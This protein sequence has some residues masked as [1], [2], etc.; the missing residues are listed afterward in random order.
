[1]W[2]FGVSAA[3][4][5]LEPEAVEPSTPPARPQ[6]VVPAAASAHGGAR[7]WL[8]T[9]TTHRERATGPTG[10]ELV[11]DESTLPAQPQLVVSA[12]ASAHGVARAWLPTLTNHPERAPG[13]AGEQVVTD[14]WEPMGGTPDEFWEE[15]GEGQLESFFNNFTDN[16][17][18]RAVLSA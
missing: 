12:M 17:C 13:P 15:S 4:P 6:L 18:R 1:M 11:T 2:L 7:A 8:P 5:T 14:E 16:S 3:L 10:E 9:L